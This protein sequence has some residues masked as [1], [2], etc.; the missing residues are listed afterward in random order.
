MNSKPTG[1][2]LSKPRSATASAEKEFVFLAGTCGRT[3]WRKPFIA[4]LEETGTPYFDPQLPSG[5]EWE[6]KH[7]ARERRE[8]LRASIVVMVVTG[9]TTGIVSL[10]ELC[11]L[12]TRFNLDNSEEKVLLAHVAAPKRGSGSRPLTRAQQ[13]RLRAIEFLKQRIKPPRTL[14]MGSVDDVLE[15]LTRRLKRRT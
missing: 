7:A 2:T 13:D 3:I 5:V 12:L 6:A 11:E 10:L 1:R 8:L 14:V 15:E 4:L 9:S